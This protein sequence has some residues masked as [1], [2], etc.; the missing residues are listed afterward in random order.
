M[1]T[2]NRVAFLLSSLIRSNESTAAPDTSTLSVGYCFSSCS[3]D[4]THNHA[5]KLI[6]IVDVVVVG[7]MILSRD[8]LTDVSPM[9]LWIRSLRME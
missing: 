6:S 2:S 5:S 4:E 8:I 7:F 1:S 9:D 3:D